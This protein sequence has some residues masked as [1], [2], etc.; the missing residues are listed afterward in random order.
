LVTTESDWK[1]FDKL[2]ADLSAKLAEVEDEWL[3]FESQKRTVQ[4]EVLRIE[5]KQREVVYRRLRLRKQAGLLRERE[6][7]MFARELENIDRLDRLEREAGGPGFGDLD[8]NSF[9]GGT[10]SVSVESSA[11]VEPVL[12]SHDFSPPALW[13]EGGIPSDWVGPEENWSFSQLLD[14]GG[15]TSEV[16]PGSS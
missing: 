16:P 15:G 13:L 7:A 11:V 2:K 8:A 4:A 6:K 3:E 1:K 10:V 12:G 5:E 9:S 14:S